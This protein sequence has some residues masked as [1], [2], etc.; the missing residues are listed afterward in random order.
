MAELLTKEI[1]YEY[2]DRMKALPDYGKQ[3]I[4]ER[5][6]LRLELQERCGLTELQALNVLNGFHV[7][8]IIAI[9]ERRNWEND[10]R[11]KYGDKVNR[12]LGEVRR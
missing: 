1:V 6:T 3:D 12:G 4:R 11:E 2:Q 10:F 8:E 9:S 7:T 5:R